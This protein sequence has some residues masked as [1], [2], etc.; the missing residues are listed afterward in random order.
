LKLRKELIQR[1]LGRVQYSD[2]A[3]GRCVDGD[4]GRDHALSRFNLTDEFLNPGDSD[5]GRTRR[6]ARKNLLNVLNAGFNEAFNFLKYIGH[7]YSFFILF[8]L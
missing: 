8:I 6:A 5:G 7:T 2:R 3:C 4:Q 1:V